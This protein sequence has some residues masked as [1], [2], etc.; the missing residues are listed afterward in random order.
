MAGLVMD[1]VYQGRVREASQLASE[2]M[3]LIESIGDETLTVGLS[4]AATFAKA[5]DRRVGRRAAVVT[6]R[7]STWPTV[8][9]LKATSSSGRR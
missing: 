2:A 5:E 6:E 3:A 4:I 1:H 8:T 7:S 9:R